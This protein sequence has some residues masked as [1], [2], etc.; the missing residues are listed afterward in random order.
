MLSGD[1]AIGLLTIITGLAIADVVASLHV[2][3]VNRERVRW[4]WLAAVAAAF[5][6]LLIIA[7][8][9]I[10]FRNMGNQQY[11]PPL[12][13]FAIRLAQIIPLYLAARASLPDAVGKEGVVLASHYEANS[14]YIWAS[15]AITYAIFLAY[16]AS[17]SGA[18]VLLGYYIS[19]LVQFVLML[20]L[21]WFRGR[22][23]HAL[24]V[25]AIFLSFCYDHLERPMFG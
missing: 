15:V 9:G 11:N 14:R 24:L 23:V 18:A 1:Y 7:T 16:N 6:T 21:I 3:L 17:S 12:W 10:S 13:V 19:P 2:L 22:R 4:D 5:V 20:M 8:W 25:P